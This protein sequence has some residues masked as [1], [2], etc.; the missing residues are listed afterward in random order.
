MANPIL[1]IG[2]GQLGSMLAQVASKI[3]SK[4]IFS[5]DPESLQNFADI[6]IDGKYNNEK[7]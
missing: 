5:D 4:L 6:F 7:N 3:K 2:G 1:G